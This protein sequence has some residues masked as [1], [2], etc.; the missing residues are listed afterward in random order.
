MPGTLDEAERLK[1]TGEFGA[2]MERDVSTGNSDCC[3]CSFD[4]P[5]EES[6]DDAV[7]NS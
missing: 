7:F 4:L 5:G 1:P 2:T 3:L 6:G